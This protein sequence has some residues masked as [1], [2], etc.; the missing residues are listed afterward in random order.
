MR[1]LAI[2]GI[3]TASMICLMSL[4]LAIR[5]NSALGANHGRDAF[6]R[7]HGSRTGFLSDT[8]LFDVHHVHDHAALQHLGQSQLEPEMICVRMISVVAVNIQLCHG[9]L[10]LRVHAARSGCDCSYLFSLSLAVSL[11]F[12][13]GAILLD[14][15]PN[16]DLPAFPRLVHS[17]SL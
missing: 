17:E 12:I 15:D 7:H 6:E 8:R 14:L 16:E 2:T 4:G 10:L 13:G 11:D 3:E 5:A 9:L 1:A